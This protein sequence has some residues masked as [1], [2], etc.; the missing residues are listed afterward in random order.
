[1]PSNALPAPCDAPRG[2]PRIA[3]FA[4]AVFEIDGMTF[5]NTSVAHVD[6]ALER[7]LA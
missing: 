5:V 2:P 3:P 1:M 4:D 6:A 7:A